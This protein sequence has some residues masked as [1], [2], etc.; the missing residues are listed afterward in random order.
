MLCRVKKLAR[1]RALFYVSEE[2]FPRSELR[3]GISC[4]LLQ[5]MKP[6]PATS[7]TS[8]VTSRPFIMRLL[9]TGHAVRIAR[10]ARFA[11]VPSTANLRRAW[12]NAALAQAAR[13]PAPPGVS[14]VEE[15]P[16]ENTRSHILQKKDGSR[17]ATQA[18]PQNPVP[19]RTPFEQYLI[20]EKKPNTVL[21]HEGSSGDVI[22][23]RRRTCDT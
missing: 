9:A 12:S 2:L 22:V 4:I 21:S 1:Q 16:H 11:T 23:S 10:S 15:P 3:L 5:F 18:P 7:C 8:S 6:T 20:D 19:S 13:P 17:S 14:G